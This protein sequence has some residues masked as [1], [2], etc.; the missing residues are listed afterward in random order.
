MQQNFWSLMSACLSRLIEGWRAWMAA[1]NITLD[2]QALHAVLKPYVVWCAER[3]RQFRKR[4][5]WQIV[6]VV[7][8][9]VVGLLIAT[10]STSSD[11]ETIIDSGGISDGKETVAT[12]VADNGLVPEDEAVMC[13]GLVRFANGFETAFFQRGGESVEATLLSQHGKELV[14]QGYTVKQHDCYGNWQA[15]AD[16]LTDSQVTLPEN[17]NEE[18]FSRELLKW[19]QQKM[20]NG[21]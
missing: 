20:T 8:L 17:A 4:Q 12:A 21:Q 7:I 6:G 3:V 18:I 10:C 9:V 19:K 15:A 1:H 2:W 11:S 16:W 14:D 5:K 13:I